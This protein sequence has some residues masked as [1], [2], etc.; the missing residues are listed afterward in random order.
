MIYE[1]HVLRGD[2]LAAI[3]ELPIAVKAYSEAGPESGPHYHYAVSQ[4]GKCYKMMEDYS[5]MV[6]VYEVYVKNI[7]NSPNIVDALF[8]LG[9]AHKQLGDLPAARE[10]YWS[11]LTK[12]GN[13]K[14]WQGFSDIT[15]DLV[16]LYPGSN[17]LN[18]LELKLKDESAAARSKD[19]LSLASRLDMALFNILK[20]QNRNTDKI[21]KRFSNLYSTNML[22]A[23]GLIFLARRAEGEKARALFSYLASAFPDSPL[24]AEAE[25]RLAQIELKKGNLVKAKKLLNSSREKVQNMKI[26][27]ELTF[28]EAELM[29]A[30][31]MPKQAIKKYEEVLANRAARGPLWPKSIFAIASAY[32]QLKDFG[33][34]IPYYQRIYV[35]YSGYSNLT[36]KAYLNSGKCF[37]KL[38]DIKSATN[39]YNELLADKR[40]AHY[41]ESERAKERLKELTK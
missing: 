37:E 11:A 16:K 30:D 22:G 12:Y 9:W 31:D 21:T 20:Y 2:A 23:D 18:E 8:K 7:P 5:N 15:K 35:M 13:N 14:D 1:A 25:L 36:A 4:I 40:L 26:A 29:L 6:S 19:Q 10:A 32:E 3:G 33:K 39:T 38:H 41:S 17:G 34:A 24:C 27:I 28:E